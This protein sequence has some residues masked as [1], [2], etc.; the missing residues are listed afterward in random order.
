METKKI[1]PEK[2]EKNISFAYYDMYNILIDGHC[3]GIMKMNNIKEILNEMIDFFSSP[4][5]EEYEKCS[6]IKEILKKL[7]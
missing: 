3:K 6:Q 2:L 1:D 7:G 5:L 4:N